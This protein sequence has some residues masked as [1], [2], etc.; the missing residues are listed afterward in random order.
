MTR[1]ADGDQI[2][3]QWTGPEHTV[4]ELRALKRY[5]ESGGIVYVCRSMG[6]R[7]AIVSKGQHG[8]TEKA[9]AILNAT[10]HPALD[11][12]NPLAQEIDLIGSCFIS[13]AI[14][15]HDFIPTVR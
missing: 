15:P 1:S 6:E 12:S 8:R 10:S 9:G 14:I 4:P 11:Q 5:L 7:A 2:N 13:R 3:N